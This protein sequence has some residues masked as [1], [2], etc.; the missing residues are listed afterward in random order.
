[1]VLIGQ[2][3]IKHTKCVHQ[4]KS[5]KGCRLGNHNEE[6]IMDYGRSNLLLLLVNIGRKRA[7]KKKKEKKEE[8]CRWVGQTLVIT[9]WSMG[10]PSP[11]STT[12]SGFTH[13]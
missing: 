11:A 2:S 12:Q 5:G 6:L 1:M 3:C 4:R 10:R 9:D 7:L 8:M 13:W